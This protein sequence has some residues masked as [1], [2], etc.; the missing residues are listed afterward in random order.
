MGACVPIGQEKEPYYAFLTELAENGSLYDCL[1]QR[2]R[3]P[4]KFSFSKKLTIISEIVSGMTYLHYLENPVFHL[5]LKTANI[6]LDANYSVRIADFGL[7]KL[8]GQNSVMNFIGG[9]PYYMAPEILMGA[10]DLQNGAKADMYAFAV[11]VNEF[12]DE[13][14]PYTSV[15]GEKDK[16]GSFIDRVKAG[17]EPGKNRPVMAHGPSALKDMIKSCWKT[18]LEERPTFKDLRQQKPWEAAKVSSSAAGD[19]NTAQLVE[20]FTHN[21]TISFSGFVKKFANI[22]SETS[23]LFLKSE[24]GPFDGVYIRTLIV[25]LD[26]AKGTEQ[27]T[28]ESVRRLLTWV[29][30]SRK[31]EILDFLYSFFTKDYFFGI[32]D[33]NSAKEY[34]SKSAKA[35]I[36]LVRWS[37]QA[38]TFVLDYIPKKKKGAEMMIESMHL[39][40]ASIIDLES[41]LS[42]TL[43]ELSLSKESIVG[44]RPERLVSLKIKEK[45]VASDFSGYLMDVGKKSQQKADLG[46]ASTESHYEFIL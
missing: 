39:G 26:L 1:Y 3:V 5:D 8:C 6:L 31:N 16:F 37:N 20:L 22:L 15:I 35:G 40:V 19:K 9:T 30:K 2:S 41:S 24:E 32:I 29:T 34:L 7:S 27:V 12:L 4:V 44:N 38:G 46:G 42:K 36:Y 18:K 45:F 14:L 23:R 28:E 21:K 33:D 25:A 17:E 11:L 10:F 13:R 43:S